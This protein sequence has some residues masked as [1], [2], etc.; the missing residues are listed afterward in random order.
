ME[1]M[2]KVSGGSVGSQLKKLLAEEEDLK[3]Q[4]KLFVDEKYIYN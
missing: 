3:T 1:Q 2:N 4:S